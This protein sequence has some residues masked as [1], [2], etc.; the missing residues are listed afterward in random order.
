MG[1]WRVL[2]NVGKS[3]AYPASSAALQS[4]VLSL[5]SFPKEARRSWPGGFQPPPLLCYFWLL[6]QISLSSAHIPSFHPS[7]QDRTLTHSLTKKE[8]PHP[9]WRGKEPGS[10]GHPMSHGIYHC[11]VLK[12]SCGQLES[13][14]PRLALGFFLIAQVK[15][16]GLSFCI[17]SQIFLNV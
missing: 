4:A 7:T 12:T 13:H 16:P 3:H 17:I 10:T 9:L 2:E 11:F 8:F 1:D 6:G 5:S 15:R 14:L